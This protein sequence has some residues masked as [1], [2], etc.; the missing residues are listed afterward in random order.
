MDGWMDAGGWVLCGWGGCF[1][2]GEC[3]AWPQPNSGSTA[4]AAAW[5]TVGAEAECSW[6][7]DSWLQPQASPSA[8]KHTHTHTHRPHL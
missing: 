1:G 7:D 8:V 2:G 6:F 4:W 5:A 3:G